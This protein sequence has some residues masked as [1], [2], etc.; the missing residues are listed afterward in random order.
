ME[1]LT[2]TE[3]YSYKTFEGILKD[4][5]PRAW[6]SLGHMLFEEGIH[7]LTENTTSLPALLQLLE[8]KEYAVF[9]PALTAF[10]SIV[11]GKIEIE[12]SAGVTFYKLAVENKQESKEN[13][14]AHKQAFKCEPFASFC[15]QFM[16]VA[17]RKNNNGKRAFNEARIQE[18]IASLAKRCERKGFNKYA[19][20]LRAILPSKDQ[21]N[22]EQ[23]KA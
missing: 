16:S 4:S 18:L 7:T 19:A 14:L 15:A 13:L 21:G 10:L 2:I 8:S 6:N 11:K 9:K 17:E 23:K 1:K 22:K 3:K 20:D 5:G 12:E